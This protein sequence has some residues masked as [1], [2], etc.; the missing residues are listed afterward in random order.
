[1]VP[2]HKA[3]IHRD[4][5]VQSS[6]GSVQNLQIHGPC[7]DFCVTVLYVTLS[8]VTASQAILVTRICV[9]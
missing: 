8:I 4:V 1:M 7:T 2:L 3:A 5:Q 9:E 6:V